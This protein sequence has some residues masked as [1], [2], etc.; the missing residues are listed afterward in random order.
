MKTIKP[1]YLSKSAFKNKSSSNLKNLYHKFEQLWQH[2][3]LRSYKAE[4]WGKFDQ[5]DP[6]EKL[7]AQIINSLQGQLAKLNQPTSYWPNPVSW[8]G[9]KSWLDSTQR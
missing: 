5:T 6:N 4:D 9:Q 2:Y 7:F 3:P 8:L 1:T